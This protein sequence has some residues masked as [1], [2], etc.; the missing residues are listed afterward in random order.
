M[1]PL[2][3]PYPGEFRGVRGKV[4]EPDRDPA[5]GQ[6]TGAIGR[7]G[8]LSPE[9][10]RNIRKVLCSESAPLYLSQMAAQAGVPMTQADRLASLAN[11]VEGELQR[12]GEAEMRFA[13]A[14]RGKGERFAGW[15][16]TKRL[17]SQLEKGLI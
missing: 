15:A 7:Q 8:E 14:L 11:F 9:E 13:P 1:K 6:Y 3:A 16:G 4:S 2:K 12:N 5:T 17:L 10:R